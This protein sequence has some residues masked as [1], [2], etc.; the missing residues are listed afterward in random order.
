MRWSFQI[1]CE[2][3]ATVTCAMDVMPVPAPSGGHP[4]EHRRETRF[5]AMVR[6]DGVDGT[7]ASTRMEPEELALMLRALARWP[8]DILDQLATADERIRGR[9]PP[10]YATP[11][12]EP[13]AESAT[14]PPPRIRSRDGRMEYSDDG[15]VWF[16]AVGYAARLRKIPTAPVSAL[17]RSC[18]APLGQ[19][20]APC[21]CT[22]AVAGRATSHDVPPPVDVELIDPDEQCREHGCAR[23]RCAE[24]H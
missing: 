4:N 18:G 16:D 5:D 23:A 22:C 24:E 15:V 14:V 20:M 13:A 11:V 7:V 10:I 17:C 6:V 19:C 3:G 12:E 21:G 9:T 2:S 1:A 8:L